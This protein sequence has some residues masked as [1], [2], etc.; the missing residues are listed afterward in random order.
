M[1]TDKLKSYTQIDQIPGVSVV[2]IGLNVE[3]YISNCLQSVYNLDYPRELLEV[4]YV[5]SGSKDKTLDILKLFP[6][7]KVI[8]LETKQPN[9]AKG[10]N[11][12]WLAAKH[13]LIQFVDADSY[14]DTRWLRTAIPQ[15]KANVGAIAGALKERFPN[16]NLF[17]RMANLEWNIRRGSEGWS[18][19]DIETLSF[20]GNVLI[21]RDLLEKT[22][23][24]QADLA[25]GEDPDLS[26]RIRRMGYKI[27]RLNSSMASHD[28]NIKSLGPF[29]KRTRRSGFVYGHLALSYWREPERYMV[30]RSLAILMGTAVPLFIIFISALLGLLGPGLVLA[31][32]ITFRLVFQSNHFARV[33]QISRS[34]ALIY[35]LYLAFC[36]YPQFLGV[37]DSLRQFRKERVRLNRMKHAEDNS[38]LN[39]AIQT[40]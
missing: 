2:V 5:D 6:S 19:K 9:A 39:A 4:I 23:G 40:N 13:K 24:Y 3:Q 17:H 31:L 29:L 25:A 35:S 18:I 11:A 10:R 33:M 1:M 8:K 22:D 36:I 34:E 21:R 32:L 16:R 12:G 30:K 37:I 38:S 27:F 14:L 26:Y 15:L 28:I 20:G 7:V